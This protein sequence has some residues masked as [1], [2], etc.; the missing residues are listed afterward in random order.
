MALIPASRLMGRKEFQDSQGI[1]MTP[2]TDQPAFPSPPQAPI[3][4]Y[5]KANQ[6]E[7]CGRQFQLKPPLLSTA[8]LL[9]ISLL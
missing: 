2:I 4:R 3:K 6:A 1:T 9:A 5:P 7:G 8:D